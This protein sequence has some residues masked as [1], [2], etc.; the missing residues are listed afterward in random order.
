MQ[1]LNKLDPDHKNN[2]E[3]Q[4]REITL[5]IREQKFDIQKAKLQLDEKETELVKFVNQSLEQQDKIN[6]QDT[7]IQRLKKQLTVEQNRMDEMQKFS[8]YVN[9]LQDC[10]ILIG[11]YKR[12]IKALT[13]KN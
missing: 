2:P 8:R 1:E 6:T 12:Q 11:D 3:V 7:Q 13:D 4:L 9:E 10:K 5:K